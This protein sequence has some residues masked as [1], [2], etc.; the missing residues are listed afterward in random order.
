MVYGRS[1]VEEALRVLGIQNLVLGIQDQSFPSAAEEDTGRGSP[2]SKGAA[3]F[4]RFV[5]ELGFN[6]VQLGPQGQT[7]ESNASPY[8]GTI[9]SRNVVSIALAPLAHDARWGGILRPETLASI[10]ASRPPS[11]GTRVLYRYA[12]RAQHAALREVFA[13]FVERRERARAGLDEEGGVAAAILR[14]D[15]EFKE[16][17][18][19]NDDWLV[20]DALYEA[21]CEEHGEAHF[22]S[23]EGAPEA[24]LDRYLWMPPPGK[25]ADCERRREELCD[26]FA[27]AIERYAFLQF[28][29]HEQHT[30]ALALAGP[31]GLKLYGDLQI[32]F[33]EQDV[34]SYQSVFLRGYRMGAPPS[35]TNPE[36]QA[37]N[38][39]VFDP[40][41]I[42]SAPPRSTPAGAIAPPVDSAPGPALALLCERLD[43]LFSEFHGV[44][45][46]HPHGLVC[47]WV[48]RAHQPDALTAVRAGA[49]LFSSPDLLDHPELMRFSIAT[50]DQINHR[51]ARYADDW[52]A[53]LSDDQVSRYGVLFEA[54]VACAVRHGRGASD[55]VCEVLS[56]MPY[57]L[58]RVM[59]RYGL[60]RFRVT[61][62]VSLT[63]PKDV[64]RSEN[65]VPEDWIMAGNHDTKPL[66]LLA[67][68]WVQSGTA[69]A[70]ARYLAERLV[71]G[72]LGAGAREAFARS[73]EA[74]P[75]ALAQAKLA[76]LF[77]SRAR[78]VM[79]FFSDLLGLKEV[80]NA[81]G[82]VND[83]NW[84]LRLPSGYEAAYREKLA[85]GAAMNLPKA[86]ATAIRSRGAPFA[87]AHGALLAALDREGDAL[88]RG[89]AP[90]SDERRSA[91]SA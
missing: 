85:A 2:F 36:G 48:Y 12:Y 7:S 10:V 5:R 27:P 68:Q 70:H 32:G 82:T 3:A 47:P 91:G 46:D 31:L 71:P 87:A 76:E 6:G 51:A 19:E 54:I 55:L 63:D 72:S 28:I 33:S 88:A 77:A 41:L 81:P 65:A 17:R 44:R 90:L 11:D 67:E 39:P 15:E 84:N 34:W 78:N 14:L 69:P 59:E 38:Y 52:V 4:L 79:V 40:D 22:R 66:W 29:A 86:L 80:F 24:E 20:R 9:F 75:C 42:A 57:P 49:R 64:Y 21:L 60:G 23:W 30:D 37:W 43:K 26:K 35:R 83:E 62:K 89:K 56:T 73:I 61:Q 8:D 16:F 74:S 25:E 50:S 45:I 18:R 53:S 13:A 58:R 1:H